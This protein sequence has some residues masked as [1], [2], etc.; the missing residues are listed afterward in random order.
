MGLAIEPYDR[1]RLEAMTALYNRETAGEPF[2]APLTPELFVAL[3]EEKSYFDPDGLLLAVE[4]GDLVG[5]VHACVA[6]GSEARHDPAEAVPRIR[7]LVY[8]R[9]RLRAGHALV[10]EA[11][12][13]LRRTG[14]AELLAMH[15]AAGYP[16]YRGLWLGGEP[17][18][19]MT[20]PH[21]QLAFEVGGYRN[22]LESVGMVA[23]MPE[24]P[25]PREAAVDLEMEHG[26]AEL[27]HEP[28]RESWIGF[29]P[30]S[31]RAIV[32]GQR[33]G[34]IRWVVIPYVAERLGA[35]CM[36]IWGMGVAEEHRRKG[37]ATAL[38]CSA[39]RRAHAMGA[40][41]ASVSTQLWNWPAQLTYAALGF[42]PHV[43]TVGRTLELQGGD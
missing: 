43:V 4:D 35:P 8:P 26:P 18:C 14:R 17:K 25:E 32:G 9:D 12:T 16:F 15:S 23:R 5:W 38:V 31:T 37:I 41:F 39:M 22:T 10:A 27:A 20:M 2:I 13:W 40:R 1:S 7:M 36:N 11:T 3:V 33:V 34:A 24:V 30:L 21:L 19:P 42:E 28:M 6:P 29:E